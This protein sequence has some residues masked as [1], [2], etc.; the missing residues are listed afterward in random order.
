MAATERGKL[1]QHGEMVGG[2]D[3][4]SGRVLAGGTKEGVN[5]NVWVH[6]RWLGAD[7]GSRGGWQSKAAGGRLLFFRMGYVLGLQGQ[8]ARCFLK[9][10]LLS[11]LTA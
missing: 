3:S 10:F 2:Q 5:G 4:G 9:L 8:E 11:D 7:G 1:R 6:W